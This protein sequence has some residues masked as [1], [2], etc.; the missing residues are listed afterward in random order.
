MTYHQLLSLELVHDYYED[1]K[2]PDF[3]ITPTPTTQKLLKNYRGTLKTFPGG[4]RILISISSNDIPFI[5]LSDDLNFTFYLQL[6]NPD[7]IL[8]TDFTEISS[9]ESPLY[10]NNNV[11][12]ELSLVDRQE[13][14]TEKLVV[15]QPDKNE[16]F[17]L[18]RKPRL[19]LSRM[20]F[21]VTGLQAVSIPESFE[22]EKNMITINSQAAAIGTQFNVTYPVK[23]KRERNVFAEIEI[24]FNSQQ[25]RDLTVEK[26]FQIKFTAKKTRWKYYVVTDKNNATPTIEDGENAITFNSEDPF[27]PMDKIAIMLKDKYPN[28]GYYQFIS[29]SLIPCR[30]SARKAIQLHLDGEKV[31]TTLP[32]PSYQNFT[33]DIRDSLE[34]TG[35]YHI[36]KYLAR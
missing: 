23:P 18:S 35:L 13:S 12:A 26:K 27:N 20:D 8:F 24:G 5:P 9:L 31:V 2:C 32:N 19:N 21:Q 30:Q 7:F 28:K 17:I 16:P 3:Q 6:Q 1:L 36:V 14:M 34:E 22:P 33:I 15:I 25:M 11:Q 10:T 4:I 29:S